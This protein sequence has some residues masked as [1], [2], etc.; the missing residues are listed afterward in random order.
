MTRRVIAALLLA[1][2]LALVALCATGCGGGNKSASFFTVSERCA[3]NRLGQICFAAWGGNNLR[4]LYLISQ[5]GGSTTLLTPSHNDPLRSDEGGFHP[6]FSPDGTKIALTSKRPVVATDVVSNDIYVIPTTGGEPAGL[7][8]L[9]TDAKTDDMANW[10][11]EGTQ[12][13]F[14]SDR[15]GHPNLH[16]MNADGTNQHALV[17][18]EFNDEWPCFNPQ[19]ANLI[20]FQSNRDAGGNP[21][22][23]N[24][25]LLNLT[26][27]QVTPVTDADFRDESP[28][29][30]P[31]G[32]RILFHSNRAGDFDIW[33][34]DPNNP[35][36]L[37]QL[38]ADSHSD[39]YPNWRIGDGGRFVFTRDRQV[40]TALPDGK[41]LAQIT[42]TF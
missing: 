12:I 17:V 18:D 11:P 26:N 15:T 32:T 40:W 2:L 14:V 24:I 41:D 5:Q 13:V 1:G 33:S 16:L 37:K 28:S 4:Y 21:S 27:M 22:I 10:S 7:T 23:N 6:A 30:S 3:Y 38:T 42:T 34:I 20:A 29:W 39:G 31:D 25:Y 35:T 19:N 8:R 9:T 36:D